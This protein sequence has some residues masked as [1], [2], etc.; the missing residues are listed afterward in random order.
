V[1]QGERGFEIA[2]AHPL[3]RWINRYFLVMLRGSINHGTARRLS[4]IG[5]FRTCHAS[6]AMV[7]AAGPR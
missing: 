6:R 2:A 1:K 5:K 7:A 4:Q 3:K